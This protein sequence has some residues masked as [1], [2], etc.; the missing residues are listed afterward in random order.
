MH[1]PSF[2][3]PITDTRASILSP[4][5]GGVLLH[6]IAPFPKAAAKI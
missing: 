3:N 1:A 2:P 6:R 4:L 5:E